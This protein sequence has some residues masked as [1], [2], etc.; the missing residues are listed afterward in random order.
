MLLNCLVMLSLMG[1]RK[2]S[3]STLTQENFQSVITG[4][5]LLK[6]KTIFSETNKGSIYAQINSGLWVHSRFDDQI[7]YIMGL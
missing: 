4:L 3:F 1:Y 5:A 6:G 7:T 2:S